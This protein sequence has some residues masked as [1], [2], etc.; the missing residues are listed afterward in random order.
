MMESSTDH[1]RIAA[2][3]SFDKNN[4]NIGRRFDSPS[5]VAAPIDEVS[6]DNN[7]KADIV[8]DIGITTRSTVEDDCLLTLDHSPRASDII[9]RQL[10]LQQDFLIAGEETEHVENKLDDI[11]LKDKEEAGSVPDVDSCRDNSSD[12]DNVNVQK[13]TTEENEWSSNN[14]LDAE[15]DQAVQMALCNH[16]DSDSSQCSSNNVVTDGDHD[17][18]CA[19][20]FSS[21]TMASTSVYTVKSAVQ[22]RLEKRVKSSSLLTKESLQAKLD[23]AQERKLYFLE[24]IIQKSQRRVERVSST[25]SM[26]EQR[27]TL[28]LDALRMGL[29]EKLAGAVERKDGQL[30]HM[31]AKLHE[32]NEKIS[33]ARSVIQE[34]SMQEALTLQEKL[35]AKIMQASMKKERYML[36]F[37][38]KMHDKMLKIT[39]VKEDAKSATEEMKKKLLKKMDT[40]QTQVMEHNANKRQRARD[41]MTTGS[42]SHNSQQSDDDKNASNLKKALDDRMARAIQKKDAILREKKAKAMAHISLARERY[43]EAN[44]KRLTHEDEY[45]GSSADR[46]PAN[47]SSLLSSTKEDTLFI[48]NDDISDALQWLTDEN[49]SVASHIS[50]T[51]S[52]LPKT[53]AQMRLQAYVKSVPS[54]SEVDAKLNAAAKRRENATYSR[55]DKA[56]VQ[57]KN[58]KVSEKIHLAE[59]KVKKLSERLHEKMDLATQRRDA[60]VKRSLQGKALATNIKIKQTQAKNRAEKDARIFKIQQRL[61]SKLLMAMEHKERIIFEKSAK[62]SCDVSLSTKR[63][64]AAS[65]A[66]ENLVQD[67]KRRSEAKLGN[68]SLRK[69]NLLKLEKQKQEVL[70]LRREIAKSSAVDDKL[71]RIQCKL[72]EKMTSAEER[73]E[74]F[75]AAKRAKATEHL[76]SSADHRSELLEMNGIKELEAKLLLQKRLESAEKRRLNISLKEQEKRDKIKARYK[77]ALVANQ[78]RRENGVTSS[79][80]EASLA[81]LTEIKEE[82]SE[83]MTADCEYNE[84]DFSDDSFHSSHGNDK[85]SYG[86]NSSHHEAT[87]ISYE[88]Q[89][90]NAKQQLL[91]EI[92]LANMAKLNEMEQLTRQLKKPTTAIMLKRD[93]SVSNESFG[94]IDSYEVLSFDDNEIDASVISGLST[95]REHDKEANECSTAQQAA[96]ALAELDIKLSEIQLMQAILLAEEASLCGKTEFKTSAQSVD[97]LNRFKVE[98]YFEEKQKKPAAPFYRNKQNLKSRARSVVSHALK[99][100]KVTKEMVGKTL[101]ALKAKI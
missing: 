39:Q 84:N 79:G 89:K 90:L 12:D 24:G 100:A 36:Q 50:S 16:L 87:S 11:L 46:S 56:G 6:R 42:S 14:I 93:K 62:A 28:Q 7:K 30:L 54:I 94:T 98:N 51:S 66:R 44:E 59:W 43:L 97:D 53:K 5:S 67:I 38:E 55:K 4:T 33:S 65:L 96:L 47:T 32:K 25:R 10:S 8:T 3:M 1:E 86:F 40:A 74:M 71:K 22:M 80:E 73:K 35:D 13:Q 75:L 29:D 17:D 26:M 77:R 19:S 60:H 101:E 85:Q 76:I 58:Q 82:C 23:A 95:L 21:R 41:D 52:S 31:V 83:G 88:Q 45:F 78:R 70:M 99:Q 64:E 34:Q 27:H 91:E 49:N 2:A 92:R 37:S 68:A 61:E 20:N 48:Q 9:P 72:Q 69:K 15:L 63:A 57:Q 81:T 18:D